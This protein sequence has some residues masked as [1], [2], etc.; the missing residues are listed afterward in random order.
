MRK[1]S[2]SFNVLYQRLLPLAAVLSCGLPLMG[3]GNSVTAVVSRPD[4]SLLS[5]KE[6]LRPLLP[7]STSPS[8]NE[9][10][11]FIVGQERYSECLEARFDAL[12]GFFIT[13]K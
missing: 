1:P 13:A 7:L 8:D 11:V 2:R 9:I 3:C 5:R 4:P 12:S 6:C 10:A